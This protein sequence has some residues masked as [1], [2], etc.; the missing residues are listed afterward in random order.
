MT[1]RHRPCLDDNMNQLVKFGF[2]LLKSDKN[3]K[4]A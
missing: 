2:L 4:D 1:T 3:L